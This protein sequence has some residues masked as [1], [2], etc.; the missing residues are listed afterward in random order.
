MVRKVR[1]TSSLAGQPLEAGQNRTDL[2]H[3]NEQ[4]AHASAR[5]SRS[6]GRLF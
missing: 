5:T 4:R 6:P 3:L 2:D 1:G